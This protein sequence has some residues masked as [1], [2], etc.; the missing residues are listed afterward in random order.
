MNLPEATQLLRAVKAFC[1][2]QQIDT[3][4]F[5]AWAAALEDIRYADASEAVLRIARRD[6]EP[7]QSRYIEPGHIRAEVRRIRQERLDKHPQV[8][9]P[10]EL[11][12]AEFLAWHRDVQRRIADGETI[13]QSKL[14]HRPMPELETLFRGV[15][16]AV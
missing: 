13:E 7:G 15:D 16:D 10:T 2:S 14:D 1:P 8:E 12:S 9:P 3:Y 5:E 11:S 6:M 4:T